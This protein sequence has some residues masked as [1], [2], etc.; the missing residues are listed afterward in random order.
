MGSPFKHMCVKEGLG[1]HVEVRKIIKGEIIVRG[2]DVIGRV[3]D[4]PACAH[5]IQ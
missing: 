4:S 3:S 5:P 1:L 2:K